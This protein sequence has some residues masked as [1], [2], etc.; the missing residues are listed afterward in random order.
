M[1]EVLSD[2]DILSAFGK[3]GSI[4]LLRR[5]FQ[6]IHV[7][8]AVYRELTNAEHRGSSW[9]ALAKEHI[10]PLPLTE[11]QMNEAEQLAIACP[12]LGSGENE[13]PRSLLRGASFRGHSIHGTFTSTARCPT[14]RTVRQAHHN[15]REKLAAL[16]FDLVK[17]LLTVI[18]VGAILPDSKIS[19]MTALIGFALTLG[20][21]SLALVITPEKEE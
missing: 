10:E 11:M 17:Y 19:M 13:A 12:Q 18:G 8:P 5:L 9:V 3:V 6:T 2:T 7:A 1:T 20:L 4:A 14:L 16:L 15:K 21:L